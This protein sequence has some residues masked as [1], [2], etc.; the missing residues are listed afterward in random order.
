MRRAKGEVPSSCDRQAT[1][2]FNKRHFQNLNKFILHG[3]NRLGEKMV[4]VIDIQGQTFHL[5][6]LKAAFWEESSCLLVADLHLG[7]AAHFRK[8]GI[9]VPSSVSDANWDRFIHLLLEFK[10]KR[11]LLLGDLFHSHLNPVCNEF[12]DLIRQF[13]AISFELIVGNHDILPEQFYLNSQLILHDPFLEMAPFIFSHHPMEAWEIPEN[14]YNIA[15]HIHP[16]V[17]LR[18]GARQRLRFPCFYFGKR[19]SIFPAF[20]LFTGMATILP[21]KGDKVYVVVEDTVMKVS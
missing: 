3:N 10:P 5:H 17:R 16:S 7:K 2:Y 18:G 14:Y 12:V 20:G 15:G 9:P 1:K 11:V 8:A 4:E 6:A 21:E 19:Q 13:H